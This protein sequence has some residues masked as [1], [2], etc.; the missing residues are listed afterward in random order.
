MSTD[1]PKPRGFAAMD[2]DKRRRAQSR[3]GKTTQA[4]GRAHNWDAHEAAVAGRKGGKRTAARAG[5]M[6]KIGSLGGTMK[7]TRAKI[8]KAFAEA[9]KIK[10]LLTGK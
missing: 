7:A 6:K 8:H 1:P 4:S 10:R 5:H 2:P 3:G 9:R